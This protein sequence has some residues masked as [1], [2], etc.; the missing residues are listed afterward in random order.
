MI[1]PLLGYTPDPYSR[2]FDPNVRC[3]YHSD[4]QGHSIEDCC[5]LKR[6]IEKMIQYKSII[7]QNID[8]EE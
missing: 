6:Q 1:T 5:A 3:V 8:S 4:F 7:V 2:S